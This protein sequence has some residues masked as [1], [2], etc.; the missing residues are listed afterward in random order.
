MRY[1]SAKVN[2]T[3]YINHATTITTFYGVFA[4]NAGSEKVRVDCGIIS[5]SC[6]TT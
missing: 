1:G 4:N 3:A 6:Y 2:A 5:N